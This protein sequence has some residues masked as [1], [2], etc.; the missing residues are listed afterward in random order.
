VPK[1]AQKDLREGD[2]RV[3]NKNQ[4][5]FVE[6]VTQMGKVEASNGVKTKECRIHICN[7]RRSEA[8]LRH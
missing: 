7:V 2:Q 4:A 3:H 1:E 8:I 5:I 6:L